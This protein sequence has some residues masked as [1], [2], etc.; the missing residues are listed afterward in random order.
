M[1]NN[2]ASKQ[3]RA[4]SRSRYAALAAA[5]LVVAVGGAFGVRAALAG[6][7]TSSDTASVAD[8]ARP[9][10]AV[11][12]GA[13]PSASASGSA[14]ASASPSASTSGKPSGS[15]SASAHAHHRSA[16]HT[17]GGSS[18]MSSGVLAHPNSGGLPAPRVFTGK[19]FDTCTAPSLSTMKAWHGSSSYGAAAVYVGGRNRGC[20]Q[21]NLTASW[22]RSVHAEGWSLIPLYVGAQ[23][24]CQ[25]GGNPERITSGNA[26]SLGASD[27]ADAVAK[28]AALGMRGGTAV[29]LDMEGYDTGD[30][31]CNQAVL[32]YVQAWTH[33]VHAHGYW[34]GFYGFTSSSA[35]AVASA[36]A[37]GTVNMPDA[38]WYARY[39]GNAST[40]TGFPFSSGLWTG[41]RRGHQYA[42]NRKETY[43]GTTITVDHDAWDAPVAVVG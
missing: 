29:Y 18:G 6:D 35:S 4:R 36:R 20:A 26:T 31:S 43:G 17:G 16:T 40:T 3:R 23:P 27:G 24:P 38:L 2:P 10:A 34:S 33:A 15:P 25:S 32:A 21:P 13:T 30:S 41:H 5:G 12:A 39:D 7:A 8:Q 22:V 37:K 19:A 42:V 11:S 9:S 1:T 28:A 14:S